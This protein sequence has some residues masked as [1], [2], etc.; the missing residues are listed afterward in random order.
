MVFTQTYKAEK[1]FP[2]VQTVHRVEITRT[3]KVGLWEG[4]GFAF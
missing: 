3:L 1:I 4:R 2:S